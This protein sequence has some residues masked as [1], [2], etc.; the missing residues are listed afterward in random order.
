MLMVLMVDKLPHC[1]GSGPV[2]GVS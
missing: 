1:V 2:I